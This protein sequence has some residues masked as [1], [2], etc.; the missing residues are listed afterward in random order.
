MIVPD[1]RKISNGLIYGPRVSAKFSP[2]PTKMS[3]SRSFSIVRSNLL[4]YYPIF[5]SL[6]AEKAKILRKIKGF[7]FLRFAYF[8]RVSINFFICFKLLFNTLL[9]RTPRTQYGQIIPLLYTKYSEN[10]FNL[11]YNISGVQPIR[12]PASLLYMRI[13]GVV[14]QMLLEVWGNKRQSCF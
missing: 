12:G 5:D 11:L 3:C 13:L 6:R 2:N 1:I 14:C 7:G 8:F 4:C 9:P 10:I